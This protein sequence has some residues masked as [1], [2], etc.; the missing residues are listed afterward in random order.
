MAALQT[1]LR[2]NK[3]KAACCTALDG[4]DSALLLVGGQ[5]GKFNA[6]S[7]ATL[8]YLFGL[9]ADDASNPSTASYLDEFFIIVTSGGVGVFCHDEN[10]LSSMLSC[11]PD[12][13]TRVLRTS[14][15][16]DVERAEYFKV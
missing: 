5:D 15:V 10:K 2:L 4:K 9:E 16:A 13:S 3:L 6:G 14:D 11:W 8:R 7:Q 1:R 12:C